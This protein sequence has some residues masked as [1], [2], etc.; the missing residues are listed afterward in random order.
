MRINLQ[1]LVVI[2]LATAFNS[3]AQNNVG[4]GTT[5]P[6]PSAIVDM[7]AT[8]KGMLVPRMTS[9]QRNAIVAP[10]EAL[11]VYDTDVQCYFYF[12]T[13]T[14]WNNLCSGLVGPAGP[15]G[16][17][18][19]MG[20]TGPAGATGA[21][22]PA[23]PAGPAGANGATGPA[24]PVGPQGPQGASVLGATGPQG[25]A[26]PAGA[27]GA[28]GPQGPIGL[29]GPAG[30]TGPQGPIGLT[31]PAG[32]DGA[33]GPQGPIGLT[34]PAGATGPQGPIGLT[35]P[36]G[37][38]GATGP[39][40]PIGLTGPTGA[41]GATGPQGPIGLTGPQGPAGADGAT[42]PQ[43]PI[44]L[45]GPTGATGATGPQGPI[46]LTGATGATG[47]TGPQGPIGLTGPAGAT[48]ATGPQGPIGLTGPAGATG[49]TGPQGPI[50]LTGA[51][52]PQGPTGPTWTLTT[53]TVNPTGTLTINATSG[54]LAPVTT[55][56]QYW[57][58]SPNTAGTNALTA[59]GYL[60]TSTNQHMDLV[61]NNLVRG[62][63]SN[64]GEFFIGTT[65]TVL[66]GD[67]MNGV[68]NTT[69]PWAV[70]GYSSF[71]GSGVYGSITS[72]ATIFA[73]VQGEYYGTNTSGAGVRGIAGAGTNNGVNGSKPNAGAGWG[74]LFQG[75]LGYTGFFGVASDQRI[76]QN[77]Q[78][79]PHAL[80]IVKSL[81]GTTYE[82]NL[83]A[84]PD[85]G[86]KTGINYGFIAQEVEQILPN[87]VQEKNIP[88]MGSTV[89]GANEEQAAEQIKTVSYIEIVP[90]LVEAIKEQQELIDEMKKEIELLKQK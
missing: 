41:T 38:D 53:P 21:Q 46:G 75:D 77:I 30:A 85:L 74:G 31:G 52:G 80:D 79:I 37:A 90:I 2:L 70:N 29:T 33:T 59:I 42:G 65:N 26:G 62:R 51:T 66:T 45:T 88:H 24:G 36:A 22:G 11:L 57:I 32:A 72:G 10:A 19:A 55:L 58:A 44:G 16:P 13:A 81:R 43:G 6:D 67:L 5:T 14:G 69:F 1:L 7:S 61:T 87:L 20:L 27:D 4:I 68:S 63:L 39:Q 3:I 34:G 49:A 47:A 25:P 82:H 35:G 8:N 17:Q 28:T 83:T 15:A 60:G 12:K 84:Y 50:G 86:L 71:N 76:K 56:G 23:G 9:A 18:G 48:G 64:L 54:S 78:T 40:G 89:R 73:G